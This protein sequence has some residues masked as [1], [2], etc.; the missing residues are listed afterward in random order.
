M[1]PRLAFAAGASVG[2]GLFRAAEAAVEKRVSLVSP[3]G[4]KINARAL[5]RAPGRGARF[6]RGAVPP[7]AAAALFWREAAWQAST[8]CLP[9]TLGPARRRAAEC[10]RMPGLPTVGT[11]ARVRGQSPCRFYAAEARRLGEQ[12]P[13]PRG[14]SVLLLTK[15]PGGTSPPRTASDHPPYACCSAAAGGGK[16]PCSGKAPDSRLRARRRRWRKARKPERSS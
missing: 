16:P 15:V 5:N 6:R 11:Y 14:T 8:E 9:A 10:R 12:R 7:R 1:R 2:R 13:Y 4:A 3:A